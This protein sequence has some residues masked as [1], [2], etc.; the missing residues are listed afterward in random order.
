MLNSNVLENKSFGLL[1]RW[2]PQRKQRNFKHFAP[3]YRRNF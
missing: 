2:L 1:Y 3:I